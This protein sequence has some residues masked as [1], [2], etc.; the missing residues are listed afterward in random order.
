[1]S[2]AD[3][4]AQAFDDLRAEVSVLRRAVE[5]LPL[6]WRDNRPPDYTEDLARVVKAM[7]AVGT[8][9]K[10]IEASP[11]LKMTPQAYGQGIR[12]EGLAASR[13]LEGVFEK[14]IGEVRKERQALA[15]IVGEA[16]NRRDQWFYLIFIG[17]MAFLFGVGVAPLLFNHI[18]WKN[19]DER[20]A[21]FIVG[22][23]DRW[24]SGAAMMRD[25]RPEQ[26][27]SFMWED[28]LVQDNMPK[29][30]DCRIAATQVGQPKS[31][32]ITIKPD[33]Q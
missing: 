10:A 21:S 7:N 8:H 20:V 32:V 12:E 27:N 31:C 13:R 11:T 15:S 23:Q 3:S 22:G 4:A 17:L 6:A 18:T 19:F 14:A 24:E 2:E 33:A 26:W 9:M 1:M 5:A 30:R 28:R 25:A 16:N 29:I